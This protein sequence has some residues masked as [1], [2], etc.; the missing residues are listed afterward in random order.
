LLALKVKYPKNIWMLRGNHE[1]PEISRLYGFFDDC[2][3][4]YG[5][6]ELFDKFT[7]VFRWLPLIAIISDRIFCV[8]G[9]LSRELADLKQIASIARPLDIPDEGLLADLLWADPSPEHS[10]YMDSDRGTSY[11]FGRDVAQAFLERHD[12]D[13]I[14]RSHQVVHNGYEFPFS[15]DQS[16][17]TVFSAANY[18][19]D[20][21]NKGAMMTV[22]GNLRC[23]FSF[24]EPPPVPATPPRPTTGM[25]KRP[26]TLLSG[27]IGIDKPPPR[28]QYASTTDNLIAIEKPAP[29]RARA[30]PGSRNGVRPK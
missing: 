7:Q 14:C 23:S 16:V 2:H 1:T 18:C 21:G 29:L 26:G 4:R 19:G 15:P 13:L 6:A 22:N 27:T 24:I 8:H 25:L 10:G 12:F 20:F 11:T 30:L 5:S 3:D 9:G 17:L 28:R